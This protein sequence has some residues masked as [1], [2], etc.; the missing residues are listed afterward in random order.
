MISKYFR[1]VVTAMAALY[2]SAMVLA[3]ATSTTGAIAS[4]MA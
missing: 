1:E 4:V 3:A 2:V